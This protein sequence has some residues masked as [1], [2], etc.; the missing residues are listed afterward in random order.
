M[1]NLINQLFNIAKTDT[2]IE[3]KNYYL[4]HKYNDI[5]KKLSKDKIQHFQDAILS[6]FKYKH[7]KLFLEYVS[8]VNS[9]QDFKKKI[10]IK[11]D[12]KELSILDFYNKFDENL[13]LFIKGHLFIE[14]A[15]NIILQKI[16]IE[17]EKKTFF[18]KINLLFKNKRID[19][20]IKK[21]L[22]A[23]NTVRNK[24]AHNLYYELT[25]P[26]V[27]ELVNLSVK[28]GIDYSE[29][30]IYENKLLSEEWYNVYGLINELF[31]NT[32]SYL[33]ELNENLFDKDEILSL[34][35]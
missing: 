3:E 14:N 34:I 18:N 19:G 11:N 21:L 16:N 28:S 35:S 8:C 15:I 26:T 6:T 4:V 31:P 22:N 7:Y 17:T 1:D 23:I 30:T 12:N 33:L 27:F 2:T 9:P 20:K 13:I 25:F 32:F 10:K 24:I 5:I 29:D